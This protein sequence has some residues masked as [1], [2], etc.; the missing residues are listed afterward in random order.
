MFV[1]IFVVTVLE[2]KFIGAD[3]ESGRPARCFGSHTDECLNQG[4]FPVVL[5]ALAPG[6]GL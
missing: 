5:N 4:C 6:T 3:I 1:K 2:D